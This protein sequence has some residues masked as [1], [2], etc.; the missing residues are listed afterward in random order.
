LCFKCEKFGHFA[1]ECWSGKGKQAKNDEGKA[2]ISQKD[3]DS[4]TVLL[5]VTTS[6]ESCNPER[7]F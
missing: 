4:D 3:S 2:K 5:M 1:F 6:N 7:W